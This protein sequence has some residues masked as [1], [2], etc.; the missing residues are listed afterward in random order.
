MSLTLS[1]NPNV[2]HL[3]STIDFRS[4]IYSKNP[5]QIYNLSPMS[6]DLY[7]LYGLAHVAAWEP[8]NLH[9]YLAHLFSVG[10]ALCRSCKTSYNG[11]EELD[12]LDDD[13]SVD[14]LSYSMSETFTNAPISF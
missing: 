14:D 5:R 7:D 1:F 3:G 2:L 4:M 9:Y 10:S 12:D 11:S 8:F 13:L 6:Y